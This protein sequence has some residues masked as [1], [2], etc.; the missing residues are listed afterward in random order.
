MRRML[1]ALVAALTA[2]A[3]AAVPAA[4]NRSKHINHV[5]V[6]YEENHSFDNLYGGW[7]GVDGLNDADAGA[8]DAGRSDRHARTRACCRTT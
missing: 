8:H 1:P 3:V 4:A 6:V 5:V 7:E 2:V